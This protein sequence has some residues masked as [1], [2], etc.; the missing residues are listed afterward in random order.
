MN[1][2]KLASKSIFTQL[3]ILITCIVLVTGAVIGSISYFI[4][5]DQLISAGKLDLKHI[6]DSSFSTLDSL[7]DR[8]ISG[9]ITLEE[10]KEQARI[11]LSGPKL[12]E[13]Y[14]FQKSKFL[15]KEEGYMLAYGLDLSSQVHPT[16]EIGIVPDNVTNRE[17]MVAGARS[18]VIEEHYVSYEDK[19]DETGEIRDKIVYM[20][21]YE[22]FEWYVGMAVYEDEFY[23]GLSVVKLFIISSMIIIIVISLILF[24]VAIRKKV[25][26]LKQLTYVSVQ[27]ADGN[28]MDTNLPESKDELGQLAVSFNKM[29]KQIKHLIRTVSDTSN[30]LLDSSTNLSAVSE[31]TSASS[32]EVGSSM[33]EITKGTQDQ[34]HALED[35]NHRVEKLTQSIEAMNEQSTIIK[36]IIAHSEDAST[37]GISIV[38]KLKKSNEDSLAASEEISVGV[39]S[40]YERTREIYHIMETIESISAETNLLALNASIE[41]ARAGEHGKGFSVVASE[42]RKLA[43][44]SSRATH[45]VQE[46]VTS[47]A[48]QTEQ[49]VE[50]V[51]GTRN[52]TKQL[53]EDVLETESKFN[54]VSSSIVDTGNA[55]DILNKEITKIIEQS[56]KI[57]DGISSSSSVSEE[58]AATVEQIGSSVEDQSKAVTDVAKL[59]EEL[60]QLNHQLNN[61]LKEYKID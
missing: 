55:L 57:S 33:E 25:K 13:G 1:R 5:E 35:I 54:Q 18:T 45:E 41:A 43:E 23:E 42:I 47:I 9:E 30:Q 7:N 2:L 59:A 60:S 11:Y 53:S 48:K 31:Q 36:D 14:D 40:L 49:T 56:S 39:K 46:V 50:T 27:I 44:Q 4:A 16:N 20:N 29:T 12:A 32:A 3:M 52:T 17:M 61:M 37:Q 26:L 58:I 15:Y 24:Y 51:E 21:Y 10:A 19:N 8:V 34:A 22:P 38:N 6:V 28:C